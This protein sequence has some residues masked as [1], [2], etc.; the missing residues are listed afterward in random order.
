MN[1]GDEAGGKSR[2]AVAAETLEQAREHAKKLGPD[3]DA[4][5]YRSIRPSRSRRRAT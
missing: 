3:L 4:R 1:I 5:F 2:W